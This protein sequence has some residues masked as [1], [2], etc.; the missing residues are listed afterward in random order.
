[1]DGSFHYEDDCDGE[2][3]RDS[4]CEALRTAGYSVGVFAILQL[5]A[6]AGI[7]LSAVTERWVLPAW[8]AVISLA[9]MTVVGLFIF[10]GQF[11]YR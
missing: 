10:L 8:Y 9:L 6:A 3:T 4:D 11:P 5:V 2:A 1:M 7:L